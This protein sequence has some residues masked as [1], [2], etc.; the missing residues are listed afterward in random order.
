MA[1][2]GGDWQ[3][4]HGATL[5]LQKIVNGG[6]PMLAIPLASVF[7]IADSVASLAYKITLA[8]IILVLSD[9]GVSR[10]ITREIKVGRSPSP[11]LPLAIYRLVAAIFLWW[12]VGVSP[13]SSS[14]YYTSYSVHL[15]ALIAWSLLGNV[16]M[17]YYGA[18]LGSAKLSTLG[19]GLLVALVSSIIMCSIGLTS[20]LEPGLAVAIA[21]A[22]GRAAELLLFLAWRHGGV[23]SLDGWRIAAHICQRGLFLVGQQFSSLVYGRVVVLVAGALLGAYEFSVYGVARSVYGAMGLLPA[24]IAHSLYPHLVMV[25]EHQGVDQAKKKVVYF[26]RRILVF[27]LLLCVAG[28]VLVLAL[29]VSLAGPFISAHRAPLAMVAGFSILTAVTSVIGFTLLAVN[30]E[31]K[32]FWLSI[33]SASGA[34]ALTAFATWMWKLPGALLSIG[35]SEVLTI[36]I[37]SRSLA[38]VRGMQRC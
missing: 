20:G 14:R 1:Q 7:S 15:W 33:L 10:L 37:F 22:S 28:V 6:L 27:Q 3:P 26:M 36:L 29:P 25:S 5:A 32:L 13:L 31:R 34:L 24:S 18:L 30:E 12:V 2:L 38:S 17:L 9:I 21:L 8:Q 11:I 19:R 35:L 23:T 4:S 16:S